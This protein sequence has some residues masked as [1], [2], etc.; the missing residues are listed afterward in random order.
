MSHLNICSV[1][2]LEKFADCSAST[3]DINEL[4]LLSKGLDL[5]RLH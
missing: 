4:V 2:P 5:L 1:L 3:K